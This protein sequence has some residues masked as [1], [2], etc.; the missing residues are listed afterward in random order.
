QRPLIRNIRACPG[1][2]KLGL[3]HAD[4]FCNARAGFISDMEH[5]GI[6][7]FFAISTTAAEHTPEIADSLFVW[8]N[9]VDPEVYRDYG[10]WKSIPVL[11]TGNANSLYPWRQKI[12]KRVSKLYPS[13]LCPHPGYDPRAAT[14]QVMVGERY[15]RTINASWFVPACGTVAKEVVR[16]HF[17]V[18]GSRA[19]LIAERSPGLE[20]AGF[21]DMKNCVFADEHDV[22]DKIAHLFANQGELDAIMDA[23]HRLVH[24]RHTM[25]NRDHIYRWFRLQRDLGADEKIVQLN[26]FEAPVAVGRMSGVSTSHVIANGLHLSL[27]RQGDDALW[28]GRY[29]EAEGLYL[30]CMSYMRWMPEP[31]LRMALCSLYR[32]D[33]GRA[34]SYVAEPIEFI[35]AQYKA[36]DP[37][38]VEWA[39]HVVSLLC[40]GRLEAAAAHAQQFPWL[41]HPELDRARWAASFLRSGASVGRVPSELGPKRRRSVHR[42]PD[43]TFDEWLGELRV[44]LAA[45]GQGRM[46]EAVAR[47]ANPL[48]EV[49]A[50]E[51]ASAPASEEEGRRQDRPV[52]EIRAR[53]DAVA[54]FRRKTVLRAARASLRRRGSAT[55]HWLERKVGYF[56]PYR[57]SEMRRDE[58]F[59]AVR[60]LARDEEIK[61][62]LV[63]GATV[64]SGSTEAFLAGARENQNRPSV[65]CLGRSEGQGAGRRGKSPDQ[66]GVEWHGF[67]SSPPGNGPDGLVSAI[68]E[69]RERNHLD[70]FDAVL[71]DSAGA[72]LLPSGGT[73]LDGELGRARFVLFDGMGAL[74]FYRRLLGDPGYSLVAHNAGLRRGY[75]IFVKASSGE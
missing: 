62:A 34:L 36:V 4:G 40:L 37:D 63:I 20:A 6:E 16:K 57:F 75:S 53:K 35:L 50:K 11:F 14:P 59:E 60:D 64:G 5:W 74:E 25:R 43:R 28:A 2:P 38:P 31:K 26:P 66:P 45:C 3:H 19:C 33:P 65:F 13:L 61:T 69:I 8:P 58:F 56:L 49:P 21:L 55:L 1:V 27:L 47:R 24:T 39:Y 70:L 48:V 46:A 12:V 42:L 29:G 51:P 7:T 9:F 52:D 67:P 41:R 22:L 44:M 73:E 32:G 54:L 68:R 71:L 23:G 30:R 72:G 10:A 15:A 18:P 17:E